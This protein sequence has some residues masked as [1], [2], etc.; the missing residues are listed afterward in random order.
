MNILPFPAKL[1]ELEMD[2]TLLSAKERLFLEHVHAMYQEVH[3]ATHTAAYGHILADAE[4][5]AVV[6][7]RKLTTE[8]LETILQERISC[9]DQE[10]P[11]CPQCT[12]K[13]RKKAKR[14]DKS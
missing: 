9:L 6:A 3:T 2:F 13:N 11:T 8:L 5:A 4:N 1:G 7:G 14:Q 10:R 12:K